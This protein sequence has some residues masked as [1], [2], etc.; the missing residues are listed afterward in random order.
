MAATHDRHLAHIHYDK[1]IMKVS[2]IY[3]FFDECIKF[4]DERKNIVNFGRANA[5]K[6]YK[7]SKD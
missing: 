3:T 5:S 7:S 4:F 6:F 1:H 2:I